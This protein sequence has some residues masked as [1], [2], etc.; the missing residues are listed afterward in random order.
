MKKL[1]TLLL[2]VSLIACCIP[3]TAFAAE[4]YERE[5][6][7]VR[8]K[9][10]VVES[11]NEVIGS[12]QS[13]EDVDYFKAVATADGYV[14][15][16]FKLE[17]VDTEASEIKDGWNYYVYLNDEMTPC[18][19]W[20]TKGKIT[21]ANISVKKGTVVTVKVVSHSSYSD[22]WVPLN[23]KYKIDIAFTMDDAWEKEN[24]DKR[25]QATNMKS[26]IQY[27]GN[28]KWDGKEYSWKT[29]DVDYWRYKVVNDGYFTFQF[30]PASIDTELSEIDNGWNVELYIG[31]NNN[32]IYACEAKEKTIN[33][34]K[35]PLKKGTIVYIK[36]T[37]NAWSHPVYVDYAIKIKS[38]KS[39]LWENEKNNTMSTAKKISPNK[40]YY[41]N[42]GCVLNSFDEPMYNA[43]QDYY[44][45]V[46][47]KTGKIKLYAGRK[48]LDN[49]VDGGWYI[50]VRTNNK[51]LKNT[52]ASKRYNSSKPICSVSVKKG[53]VIYIKFEG[54][55]SWGDEYPN[56]VDYALKVKNI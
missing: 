1:L 26:G 9:A 46:A 48:N 37:P 40:T 18:E 5:P 54:K 12:L 22:K 52:Y 4:N 39:S 25:T 44:K 42:L 10:T 2:S 41:G 3:T 50:K 23:V 36:V 53:Q 43:D 55:W 35:F 47:N 34:P 8:S 28:M 21:G 45:V 29:E 56:Y 15:V 24:N 6:N 7:D 38:V 20:E 30:K 31:S 19:K 49:E 11:G 51:V 16:N 17:S 14:N 27:R 13:A 32:P 33:T